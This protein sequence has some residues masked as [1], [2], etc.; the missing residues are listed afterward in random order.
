MTQLHLEQEVWNMVDEQQ[1]V[2][3]IV[4]LVGWSVLEALIVAGIS[5][6][7]REP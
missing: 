6:L 7:D 3:A 4:A 5:I 2:A 1:T